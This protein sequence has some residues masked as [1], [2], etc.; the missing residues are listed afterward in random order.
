[1]KVEVGADLSG[2]LLRRYKRF[3]ADVECEDGRELTVHC[4]NPGSMRGLLEIGAP[5]WCST[6]HNPRR[7]LKHT[8]EMIRI[9][10]VWVGLHTLRANQIAAVV[11]EA[12][13]IPSLSGYSELRREVRVDSKSR[14]DFALGGH[15]D[16]PRPAFVE[17]KSVTMADGLEGR[18]PD[19]VTERGR[20]HAEALASLVADGKRA[21]LLFI[22]QREDCESFA[23]ADD[24]DPAYGDALRTAAE[25]GVELFALRARVSPEAIEAS[26]ELPI[27]L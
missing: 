13:Y 5:V 11:L 4:P 23:P 2:R 10:G 25:K 16:D 6:S 1:M 8:L 3:F 9:A 17:V 19:S 12:G 24:I 27:R 26:V 21:A 18:F 7:K 22:V 14:I 20:K 15:P